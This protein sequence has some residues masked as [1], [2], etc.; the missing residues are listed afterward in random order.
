MVNMKSG[1]VRACIAAI[2]AAGSLGLGGCQTGSPACCAA[3]SS[4]TVARADADRALLGK[5]VGDW[6]FEGS[7]SENGGATNNVTG[8]AA[9]VLVNNYF[10][11]MDVQTT[12]GQLSGRTSRDEGSI[13]FATEPGM[14][15]TISAWGDASP[16]IT[17]LIGRAENG[18][19][20]LE[21]RAANSAGSAASVVV[22]FENENRLTIDLTGPKGSATYR[23]SRVAN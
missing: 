11:M 18:G 8:R 12:S 14:G 21:Y 23:F 1:A 5:L 6:R 13:L 17:R 16:A 10:V 22:R 7:W 2:V 3:D 19:S 20:V 15:M 9:G 4:Y